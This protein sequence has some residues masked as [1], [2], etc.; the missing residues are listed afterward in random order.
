MTMTNLPNHIALIP[1]G[2][3]RWARARNLPS[4]AGHQYAS[5]KALPDLIKKLI[6]FKIKYFTFWALS[7]E[8]LI[9]RDKKELEKLFSLI[10]IFLKTKLNQFKKQGIKLKVIGNIDELS[11]DV[12]KNIIKA[13]EVTK[14][15]STLT[16]ILALNYGGRDEIIRTVNKIHNLKIK[17][18]INKELFSQYLDTKNIPDPDLIIRTGGEKRLSGFL[19]WQSEY[20][21]LYFTEILFPDFNQSELEKAIYDYTSRQR[22]LGQ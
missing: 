6:Q 3:R 19:P 14:K 2:N 12:Q 4:F 9:K 21:E 16:L 10:R 11:H 15:N 18:N 7:T 1:D 22:R 8:N 20:S 13:I 17:G 5:E